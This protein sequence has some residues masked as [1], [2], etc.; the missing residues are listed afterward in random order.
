MSRL[1]TAFAL[2]PVQR[3]V[4]VALSNSQTGVLARPTLV[5]LAADAAPTPTPNRAQS[6]R[7]AIRT[8]H[9]AGFLETVGTTPANAGLRLTDAGYDL[10]TFL[11]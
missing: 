1:S 10:S 2:G 6:A 7:R 11:V 8:L 4:I 9:A 5:R 3:R